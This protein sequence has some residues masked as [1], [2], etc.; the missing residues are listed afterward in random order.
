MADKLFIGRFTS[1]GPLLNSAGS[2]AG[3]LVQAQ[4]IRELKREIGID[5]VHTIVMEPAHCFPRG[6]LYIKGKING[7]IKFI[8]FLNLPLIKNII[9]SLHIFFYLLKNRTIDHVLLYNSYLFENMCVLF[10]RTLF[11]VGNTILVQDVRVGSQFSFFTKLQDRIANTL[12]HY[13]DKIIPINNGIVEYLSLPI[14]KVVVFEGGVES[15][16]IQEELNNDY[17]LH[18]YAVFAGALEPHNGIDELIKSWVDKKVNFTLHVFGKGSLSTFLKDL[19]KDDEN[20]IIHGMKT[21]EEV[22]AYQ[23]YAKFNFCLRNSKG[24]NEKLFFPSK[25]FNSALCSGELVVNDFYGLTLGMKENTLLL[26]DDFSNLE[27]IIY[28]EYDFSNRKRKRLLFLRESHCWKV[29]FNNLYS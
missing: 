21:Q 28:S 7:D 16:R 20:I 25:F 17:V 22:F 4:I 12:L 1:D 29:L 18:D 11:G 5:S 23:K 26:K 13:F 6:K 8:P 3:D 24:L 27:H 2:S 10:S 9:F 19:S 14:S 15:I